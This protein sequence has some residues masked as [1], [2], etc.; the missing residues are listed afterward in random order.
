[1]DIDKHTAEIEQQGRD[2]SSFL[3]IGRHS[4]KMGNFPDKTK[5]YYAGEKYLDV[6]VKI[7]TI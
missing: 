7:R 1:M 2:L 6:S 4:N 5:E 3:L